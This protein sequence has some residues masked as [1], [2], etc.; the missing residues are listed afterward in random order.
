MRKRIVDMTSQEYVEFLHRRN[1]M[2]DAF[3]Y[4]QEILSEEAKCNIDLMNSIWV[5]IERLLDCAV[6]VVHV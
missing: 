4:C 1:K 3:L 2:Y 6:E 5:T